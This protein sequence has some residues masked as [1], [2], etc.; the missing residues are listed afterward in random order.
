MIKHH[1]K[2]ER[3]W[4]FDAPVCVMRRCKWVLG[5]PACV[6][7][8]GSGSQ[9]LGIMHTLW[10]HVLGKFG[11]TQEQ[12]IVIAMVSKLDFDNVTCEWSFNIYRGL[13]NVVKIGRSRQ[14]KFDGQN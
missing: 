13:Q 3:E 9:V 8:T 7:V 2:N 14:I 10:V 5:K 4:L 6:V 1:S 12:V 11:R